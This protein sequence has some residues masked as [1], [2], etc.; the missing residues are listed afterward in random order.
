MNSQKVVRELGKKYPGKV[1]FPNNE[2]NPT[3]ILCE[4]EPASDHPRYSLAVSVIDKSLPHFHKKT[5]ETYKVVKGKLLLFIDDQ[6]HRLNTGDKFTIEPNH[7]HWAEG[8]ETWVECYSEPGWTPE[9]H[10][11][12]K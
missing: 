3:E 10:F 4:V 2:K 11:L 12:V 5:T 8:E 9:D 6:P 7:K 1:V